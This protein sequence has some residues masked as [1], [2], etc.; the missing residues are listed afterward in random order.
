ME[1]YQSYSHKSREK[2]KADAQAQAEKRV[3]KAVVSGGASTKKKS[4]IRKIAD[5]FASSDTENVKSYILQD[6]IVPAVKRVLD[7]LIVGSLRM[8]LYGERGTSDGRRSNASKVSYRSYYERESDRRRDNDNRVRAGFE[9]DDIEFDYR[10]DAEAVLTSME[11]V[12]EQ[13]D[14]VSVNDLYDLAG[15]SNNNPSTNRYGWT[16]LSTAQ[17][18]RTRNGK[19]II[20]LPRAMPLN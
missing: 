5:N 9:Y 12:I 7:D 13:Y 20:K 2:A 8:I 1:E 17:I 4:E 14:I 18:V 16:N 19:Y 3:T 15:I 11:D 6:V 10:G